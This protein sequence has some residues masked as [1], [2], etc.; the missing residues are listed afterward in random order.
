[1]TESLCLIQLQQNAREMFTSTKLNQ[2]QKKWWQMK[3][4]LYIQHRSDASQQLFNSVNGSAPGDA[5]LLE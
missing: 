3:R 1:V 2:L 5:F 4:Y